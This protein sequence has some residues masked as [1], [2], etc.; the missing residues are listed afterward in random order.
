MTTDQMIIKNRLGLLKLAQTLGSV[1][2][3]CNVIVLASTARSRQTDSH[4]VARHS[5][6]FT[7]QKD[8][9]GF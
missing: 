3:A 4:S 7:P 6:P 1:S 2:E 9:T 5:A 8:P